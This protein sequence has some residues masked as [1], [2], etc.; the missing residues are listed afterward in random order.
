MKKRTPDP[1][2][3]WY[4]YYDPNPVPYPRKCKCCKIVFDRPDREKE[5]KHLRDCCCVTTLRTYPAFLDS[6]RWVHV[7]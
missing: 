4:M 5:S 3:E 7:G 1:W 6:D 2:S